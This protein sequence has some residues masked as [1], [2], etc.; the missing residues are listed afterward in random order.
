MNNKRIVSMS[1]SAFRAAVE[2]DMCAAKMLSP[3]EKGGNFFRF[4]RKLSSALAYRPQFAC[5]FWYR[6]NRELK[7]R[8]V[9]WRICDGMNAWRMRQFGNDI[10]YYAAIGPGLRLG[11]ISDI[12]IGGNV[13]IGSHA[14]L[15]NG[16]TIGAK[17]RGEE[18]Q[19]PRLGN[20]VFVGSGA[21]VLGGITVGNGATIG[22]LTLCNKD[23][24]DGA[25]VYGIP[26]HIA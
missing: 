17:K 6:V 9:S 11:H 8:N 3:S 7:A 18:H 19:M 23:V 22:A 12:V 15:Y 26:S 24:P 21:K 4:A 20:S 5:V 14:T 1:F 13:I 10:S 2:E 25:T 16:V